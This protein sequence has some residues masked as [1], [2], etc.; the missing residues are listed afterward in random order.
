MSTEA[1]TDAELLEGADAIAALEKDRQE[2][3]EE[4]EIPPDP[5]A[6]IEFPETATEAIAAETQGPVEIPQTKAETLRQARADKQ[7]KQNVKRSE[8]LDTV[9]E[10][11]TN[12]PED[13]LRDFMAT[14]P[15]DIIREAAGPV[16]NRKQAYTDR[17]ARRKTLR[18][19]SQK[20]RT[21]E[22]VRMT[23]IIS[24]GVVHGPDFEARMPEHI[25]AAAMTYVNDALRNHPEIGEAMNKHILLRRREFELRQNEPTPAEVKGEAE[26]LKW[27]MMAKLDPE[28]IE[29]Y[30]EHIELWIDRWYSGKTR[31]ANQQ[32]V[33]SRD[34]Q[35]GQR[36]SEGSITLAQVEEHV[37]KGTLIQTGNE[38]A[39]ASSKTGPR[40][41]PGKEGV[42]APR[43]AFTTT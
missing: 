43:D 37:E 17:Q 21:I 32:N 12:A 19:E 30:V 42:A 7:G 34:P 16:V 41:D 3:E 4:Y 20:K 1:K 15:D 29:N 27:A 24:G 22:E 28:A 14:I 33:T 35:T 39:I 9:I 6:E 26:D 11:L 8:L 13:Q 38:P 10:E 31:S 25:N 36:R 5:D 2:T 23:A 40:Y 18:E